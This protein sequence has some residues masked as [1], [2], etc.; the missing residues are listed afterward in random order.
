MEDEVEDRAQS[1][2]ILHKGIQNGFA[3]GV[4]EPWLRK[5]LEGVFYRGVRE[6][7]VG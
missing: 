1:N 2:H 5:L 3:A 4:H 7:P 6:I